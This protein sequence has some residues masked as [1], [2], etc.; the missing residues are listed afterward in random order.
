MIASPQVHG[1]GWRIVWRIFVVL[2]LAI[3][4]AVA[5]QTARPGPAGRKV[6]IS[7]ADF[8]ME[9]RPYLVISN[10]GRPS[11]IGIDRRAAADIGLPT[12]VV[13]A[14]H[15]GQDEGARRNGLREKD[16]TLDTA[17]RVEIKLREQGFPVV[18]TRREDRFVELSERSD[19]ANRHP[20][21]LFISIHF[22]DFAAATGR[23]VETF[24]ATDKAEDAVAALQIPGMAQP[25]LESPPADN[26]M[27]FAQAMQASMLIELGVADR[28]VKAAGYAVIR[29]SHCP[30][31][32]I[33]G[34]FIN[35]PAQAK[36]IGTPEYR[37]KLATAIA[38]AI[39]TYN[40]QRTEVHR[41]RD[42]QPER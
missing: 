42:S 5:W 40:R 6:G 28:G 33:E 26:G 30:A 1:E 34:G 2:V 14:G 41:T 3:L 18:L 23:G 36:E 39:A 31:V 27:A 35:N 17:L 10:A 20:Y 7:Q 25:A 15:G 32:L 21:A 11:V 22:N 13:D 4:T 24:Y 8:D 29:H 9:V 37:D 16:L 12:I 19:V 38:N